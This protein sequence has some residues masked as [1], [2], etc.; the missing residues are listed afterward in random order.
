MGRRDAGSRGG[1]AIPRVLFRQVL[2]S[3]RV[4]HE[5]DVHRHFLPLAGILQ[6]IVREGNWPLWNHPLVMLQTV[7]PPRRRRLATVSAVSASAHP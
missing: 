7:V 3:G 5:R 2:F 4:F 1:V 6:L